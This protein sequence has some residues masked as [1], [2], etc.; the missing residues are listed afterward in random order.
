MHIMASLCF[1]FFPH[2]HPVLTK[3]KKN[4]RNLKETHI[5]TRKYCPE[6]ICLWK[7]GKKKKKKH[8][9]I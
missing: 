8:P 3:L 5:I 2:L 7:R 6:L 1:S 9:I 4:I